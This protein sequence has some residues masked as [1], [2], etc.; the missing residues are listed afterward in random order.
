MEE[1]EQR[2][3]AAEQEAQEQL[4]AEREADRRFTERQRSTA[5]QVTQDRRALEDFNAT[6]MVALML[7]YF[8]KLNCVVYLSVLK[9]RP[10]KAPNAS[11]S[12]KKSRSWK[13]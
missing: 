8:V 9:P 7:P 4:E 11:S 1:K 5:R 13:R 3:R 2:E 6:L 10:R 12:G